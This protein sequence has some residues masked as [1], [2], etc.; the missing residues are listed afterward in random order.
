[1]PPSSSSGLAGSSLAETGV[2]LQRRCLQIVCGAGW[3]RDVAILGSSVGDEAKLYIL[4][5]AKN[6]G[7]AA[8]VKLAG[9]RGPAPLHASRLMLLLL[10]RAVR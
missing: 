7:I 10:F 5:V 4:L 9:Y 1:M 8:H 3:A 2:D 6:G